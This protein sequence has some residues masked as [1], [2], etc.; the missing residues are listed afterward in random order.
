MPWGWLYANMID[1][2]LIPPQLRKRKKKIL[3]PKG[4]L[5]LP[6]EA[7]FGLVGGVIALLLIVDVFAGSYLVFKKAVRARRLKEWNSILPDKKRVDNILGQ[8]RT[9]QKRINEIDKITSS[10]FVWSAKLNALSDS[11][12][13]GIWLN[14]LEYVSD[15][16]II[17]GSAVSKRK[18]EMII[19][20]DFSSGPVKWKAWRLSP[21]DRCVLWR[22]R[23][24]RRVRDR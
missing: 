14:K 17:N 9:L 11:V 8:I 6:K 4:M 5:K 1:I 10:P 12:P 22:H 13:R 3:L 7:L 23:R 15:Q 18:D 2:N 19:V 21:P 20:E 24:S 16:L